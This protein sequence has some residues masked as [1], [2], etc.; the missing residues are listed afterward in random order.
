MREI[1]EASAMIDF[2]L[3]LLLWLAVFVPSSVIASISARKSPKRAGFMMQLTMLLLSLTAM[4]LLGGFERFGFVWS[5]A[6]IG[7]AFV[8]GFAISL[9]LNLFVPSKA[10]PGFL[11]EGARK[12]FLLL[13]LAPLSEEA[14]N[15]GL[16][17]G[18]LLNH[19]HFWGAITFSATLFALP[20]LMAFDGPRERAVVLSGAFVLGLLAGYIFALG[21]MAP[22]FVLHSSANLAGLAVLKFRESRGYK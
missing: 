20:H 16:L 22:A 17:E 1:P 19:G 21:G 7:Q 4:K 12:F 5:D 18:Y 3:A 14:L 11:P 8:L 15:R 6:Y 9:V 10:M 13:L 2:V